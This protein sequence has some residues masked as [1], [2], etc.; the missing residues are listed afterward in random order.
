ME[1][2]KADWRLPANIKTL[3]SQRSGG[4]SVSPYDSFNLG[5][6]VG[7]EAS[8]VTANRLL[9]I[10]EGS[11]PQAPLFLNQIHSTTVIEL[12]TEEA[13][14]DADAVYTNQAEQVCVVMTA[15]C[16]PVLFASENGNEVAAAHAGW[17]GLSDGVLEATIG[18]FAAERSQIHAWLGP[19]IGAGAFQVGQEVRSRFIAQ[20]PQAETAFAADPNQPQK[21]LCDLYRLAR[22]RLIKCGIRHIYGGEYCTFTQKERFFSYRRDGKTG[23]MASL[24]WFE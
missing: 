15:D 11:L 6:H 4:V 14:P 2:I 1:W 19:A 22:Q 21:Y 18:K 13:L 24:I 10:Q 12:P 5:N 7:D 9:L 16:L 17:R 8:A 23:R 3:S 20:D